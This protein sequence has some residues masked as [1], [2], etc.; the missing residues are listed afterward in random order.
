MSKKYDNSDYNPPKHWPPD[1]PGRTGRR[2]QMRNLLIDI[3]AIYQK[4]DWP[5]EIWMDFLCMN[6]SM[7]TTQSASSTR[8]VD[9]TPA[10]IELLKSDLRGRWKGDED[11]EDARLSG[12]D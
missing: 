4:G 10:E 3:L 8:A 6:D 9:P 5:R 2:N 1:R 12:Q 11:A 7:Q